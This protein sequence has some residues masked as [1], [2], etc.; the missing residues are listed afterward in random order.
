MKVSSIHNTHT[1]TIVLV[2]FDPLNITSNNMVLLQVQQYMIHTS[3]PLTLLLQCSRMF[4][5]TTTTTTVSSRF[6]TFGCRSITSRCYHGRS[7]TTS[8]KRSS[9]SSLLHSPPTGTSSTTRQFLPTP[10]ARCLTTKSLVTMVPQ[11]NIWYQNRPPT[12]RVM[13]MTIGGTPRIRYC[14]G[15][16]HTRSLRTNHTPVSQSRCSTNIK[17][18]PPPPTAMN[19]YRRHYSLSN[20]NTIITNPYRPI[21]RYVLVVAGMVVA[22]ISIGGLT[23][24]TQSGLSMT[25][26]TWTGSIPPLTTEQWHHE[27]QIYQ[28]YP[29]YHQRTSM[30][31]SD[32]Q[33]IYM[34]EYGHRMMGRLIGLA[35][36]VPYV[37]FSVTKQIPKGY[38]PRFLLIGS[39][40]L[41]QGYVGWWMVQS[42]LT[43]DRFGDTHE[44]RVKP[45]RLTTHLFMAITTYSLLLY[46]A[47]DMFRYPLLVQQLVQQNTAT[48]GVATTVPQPPH[49]KDMLRILSRSSIGMITL[50]LI[51]ILSGALVAGNDAGRAYNTFPKMNDEWFPSNYFGEPQNS[52][53]GRSSTMT[54]E[55]GHDDSTKATT[56]SASTPQP[57]LRSLLQNFYENTA[58]VQFNHRWCGM[59]TA[60]SGISLSLYGLYRIYPSLLS[61]S[62]IG[63]STAT[64][65][66]RLMKVH[67]SSVLLPYVR[68]GLWAIGLAVTGQFTLGVTTLVT[69][70][71]ISLAALHQ[72]GS[73]VVLTS[74]IYLLHTTR[75]IMKALPAVTKTIS[76]TTT[77]TTN[78]STN[79]VLT[80]PLVLRQL[81]TGSVLKDKR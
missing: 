3:Q 29:E 72:I 19:D 51:T 37:Y 7:L 73:I 17:H 33:Y 79:T 5:T 58:T 57:N 44:I 59:T 75:T 25:S 36:V 74:S 48:A 46:T 49:V 63:H 52:S 64:T 16:S 20:N 71:P 23:R 10:T 66:S 35:Y 14:S 41:L 27:F 80:N 55:D 38:H 47:L 31:L 61:L 50:T 15:M 43:P 67:P 42:G 54:E 62:S 32:F 21:G 13:T 2:F 70:V 56:V 28:Q 69:Y 78:T 60:L 65:P 45:L 68:T 40:G 4:T 24:L 26:W 22:M 6:S 8:W 53:S 76:T 18:P 81:S 11:R 12:N 77:T 39:I 34:W 9:S 1:R 30:T